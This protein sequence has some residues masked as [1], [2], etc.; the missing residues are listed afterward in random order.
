MDHYGDGHSNWHGH[1]K[2]FKLS[3]LLG[4]CFTNDPN[5]FSLHILA[6]KGRIYFKF[7]GGSM[8]YA[9][10]STRLI[11]AEDS[12]DNAE[13]HE[14]YP[15]PVMLTLISPSNVNQLFY[16]TFR[17]YPMLSTEYS[18]VY[19]V[20]NTVSLHSHRYS[21]W[22]GGPDGS[23]TE[24]VYFQQQEDQ[25]VIVHTHCIDNA[26]KGCHCSNKI[27]AIWCVF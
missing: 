10:L 20:C 17:N 18:G 26:I 16:C 5:L 22:W 4:N 2:C 21:T 23:Q 19:S 12:L 24:E 27:K 11:T 14:S 3:Y 25:C 13:Q 1:T 6:Q 7:K 8:Q 15:S 9:F